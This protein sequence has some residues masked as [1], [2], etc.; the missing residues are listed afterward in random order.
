MCLPPGSTERDLITD[1]YCGITHLD[2]SDTNT[3][4]KFFSTHVILSPYNKAVDDINRQVMLLISGD[5]KEYLSAD[6]LVMDPGGHGEL[7]I[8]ITSYFDM[9]NF[10]LHRL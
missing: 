1:V 5:I 2:F 7:S 6:E 9:P 3:I 8:D 4:A 10:P